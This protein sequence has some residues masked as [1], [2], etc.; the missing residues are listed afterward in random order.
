MRRALI[1]G[2]AGRDFHNFNVYFRG[3][4]EYQVVAFTAA[5]IPFIENRVY[6]PELAG[7]GYP[8]GIPIVPEERLEETIRENK[9]TDVFFSYSDVSFEHV[10]RLASRS[11]ALGASFHL[12]GPA[13]T[14]LVSR[15]PVVAVVGGR[16]G[17][18]KSTVSRYVFSVL[19]GL[20]IRAIIVR[21]PMPYGRLEAEPQRFETLDDLK[22]HSLT[23]EEVEEYEPHVEQGGVVYAGVDYGVILRR[24]EAEGDVVLW[25]GGNNDFPFYRPDLTVTVVDA[26]RADSVSGSYPGEANVRSADVIV[27]NKANLVDVEALRSVESAVRSINGRARVVVATSELEVDRPELIR[28]KRC[29]AVE[30]APSVTHGGMREG[31]AAVAVRLHGG[32]LVDPRGYAVGTVRDAYAKYPHMA[33]VV[34]ALGYSDSQKADLEATLNSIPA[35][36]IVL[37]T[38]AN[39]GLFLKLNKPIARVTY[40]LKED[41]GLRDE[42]EKWASEVIHGAHRSPSQA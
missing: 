9:V 30:D 12:L 17:A 19:K 39:L 41:G 7:P 5:Q 13:D 2:A 24:A 8:K 21:H 33:Y 15:R 27:I 26:T 10:M 14:Q 42:L 40:R 37:G 23:F 28:G 31:A 25:D 4:Q 3:N 34:P 38:P 16:T 35:D 20:G 36:T 22:R 6:P 11:M 1:L 29:I 18:G 32:E